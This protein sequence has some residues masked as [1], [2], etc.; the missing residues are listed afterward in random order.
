MYLSLRFTVFNFTSS[1]THGFG[2]ATGSNTYTESLAV[3]LV[4]FVSVLYHYAL[5]L[6]APIGLHYE[7]D[8]VAY[9]T[10]LSAAGIFGLLVIVG[11]GYLAY[12]SLVR[13]KGVF[14]LAYSW[15]FIAL[16]PVSGIIPTN[17][18]YLEHWLY[19]PIIGV[20]FLAAYFLQEQGR[21]ATLLHVAT[22]ILCVYAI[23]SFARNLDW[24]DPIRFYQNELQYSGTARMY[25]NLG[26]ELANRGDCADAIP[27]YE[28]AI[29]ISDGYPQ[30]HYDLGRCLE[31]G[32]NLSEAISEYKK[33][34]QIDPNFS[35]SIVRLQALLK[36]N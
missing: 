33:S 26:L 13:G 22:I 8:Y 24:A 30:T 2:I 23:L 27:N 32:G 34:L 16:L 11:G 3:R 28:E 5:F 19:V 14:F 1:L 15:F 12:R 6:L 21:N 17:A 18:M 20:I 35:Y 10:L 29:A 9:Y 25:S 4:T 7:T 36:K 31:D